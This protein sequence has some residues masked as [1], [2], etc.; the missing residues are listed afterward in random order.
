MSP[1]QNKIQMWC[2]V[3]AHF[4]LALIPRIFRGTEGNHE[5]FREIVVLAEIRT[6]DPQNA[7][8][9]HYCLKQLAESL[10]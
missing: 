6:A 7:N 3:L 2:V 9:G 5:N 4:N 1:L 10:G 8:Q